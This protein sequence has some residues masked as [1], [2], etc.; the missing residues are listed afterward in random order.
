VVKRLAVAILTVAVLVSC[1]ARTGSAGKPSAAAKTAAAAKIKVVAATA[2]MPRPFSYMGDDGL[3][4]H[5]IELAKAILAKLP[6][7]NLVFEVT[8]FPSM[9]AGMDAGRYALAVN[10]FVL[11]PERKE[12][13]LFSDPMFA[14][15][16][17]AVVRESDSQY[18]DT[19]DSLSVFAGKKARTNIGT[20]IYT[21]I[22]NY[23]KVNPNAKID[24]SYSDSE[25]ILNLQ[26]V[27]SGRLDFEILDAPMFA[28]YMKTSPL[29]LRKI[30]LSDKA[31]AGMMATP[32]SYILIAK[33]QDKLAAD[34]NKALAEVIA[35]GESKAI[36][37]KYFGED[38]TPYHSVETK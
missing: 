14:N 7:Y 10:N 28:Y 6:Q 17:V 31:A 33:G 5:N 34:I 18:P 9:F 32:Y 21:A 11:T 8:D 26:D 24:V 23:N 2:A 19:L 36:C 30:E 1:G 16:Y 20:N 37:E 35:D 4:G 29:P 3:A 15:R 12:K 13:Y 27:V 22:E 38:Y 25:E